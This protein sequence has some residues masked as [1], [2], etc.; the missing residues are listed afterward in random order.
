MTT[1]D[2]SKS[3]TS[4][5]FLGCNHQLPWMRFLG[6]WICWQRFQFFLLSFSFL[7]QFGAVNGNFFDPSC[8]ILT[9]LFEA[10]GEGGSLCFERNRHK[11]RCLWL[12][13]FFIHYQGIINYKIGIEICTAQSVNI[14]CFKN[15]R[16]FWNVVTWPVRNCW[17]QKV[18]LV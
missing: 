6:D 5:F 16:S 1:V 15:Y 4:F 7:A 8:V 10:R 12:W 18:A 9:H 3:F 11:S 13:S 17:Y 14:I 2:N